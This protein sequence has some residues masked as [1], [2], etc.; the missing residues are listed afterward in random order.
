[1]AV[2]I[3][4][5]R[6][7]DGLSWLVTWSTDLGAG[8]LFYVWLEGELLTT[9]TA[10]SMT[11]VAAA[12][13][14]NLFITD[15]AAERP[16][17]DASGYFTVAWTVPAG[18][19]TMLL[20]TQDA[21]GDWT[22]L[23]T[24]Q[25]ANGQAL[26]LYTAGYLDDATGYI[27]G[28]RAQDAAGNTSGRGTALFP[29]VRRPDVPAVT[30]AY[31][32]GTG[33]VTITS[34]LTPGENTFALYKGED[35][36]V[37]YGSAWET[38]TSFPH[39]TAAL[40]VGT[41]TRLTVRQTNPWRLES[42]ND[43]PTVFD[44]DGAGEEQASVPSD[45]E[46]VTIE[47][48]AG[49]A[50][51]IDALYLAGLDGY[52]GPGTTGDAADTW[53][54]WIT[55][56]GSTPDPGDTP[57]AT[58]TM[59]LATGWAKLEYTSGAYADG[60]TIKALVRVRRTADGGE[61]TNTG[62]VTTTADATAPGAPS[63]SRANTGDGQGQE[64]IIDALY[65]DADNYVAL[66]NWDGEVFTPALRFYLGGVLVMQVDQFGV[67]LR[68][69]VYEGGT[70]PGTAHTEAIEWASGYWHFAA[71]ASLTRRWSVDANGN[72]SVPGGVVESADYPYNIEGLPDNY[73]GNWAV[74]ANDLVMSVDLS[75][76]AAT[77]RDDDNCL[78]TRTVAEGAI[79]S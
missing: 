55:D 54:I 41:V 34:A 23:Q 7:I 24:V 18:T 77:W 4:S 3:Q 79:S 70:A 39:E 2:T 1:M 53:A 78:Y 11:V 28:A 52:E 47:A 61:S 50:V 19:E 64:A 43:N 35:G 62:V 33:T 37:D 68:G 71:G 36:D 21:A 26:V 13:Y 51:R 25:V 16:G 27:Y 60:A 48:A 74:V 57:T 49:G 22:T 58:E 44:L 5:T 66:V 32:S 45:P 42:G 14:P 6:Q 59:A 10:T 15:D 38:I 75:A 30:M 63:L 72:L 20:E 29:M 8:T 65:Q 76:V 40:A 56:D 12:G 73:A 67:R 9:T 69:T 17:G 31:D 46:D